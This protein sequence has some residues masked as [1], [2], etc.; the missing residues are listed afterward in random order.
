M[1]A[2][3]E[4]FLIGATVSI[5]PCLAFCSPVIL[6]YIAA[7]R[8]GWREGL[9]AMLAFSLARLAAYTALGLMAGL[10]GRWLIEAIAAFNRP[11]FA[12]SGLFI[13]ALGAFI[14][15]G[16]APQGHLCRM[17]QALDGELK[18]PALLGL[19]IGFTPC[20]PAAAVLAYIALKAGG[21][22][23]G[24][25]YGLSFGLGKALSLLLPLGVLSSALPGMLIKSQR[26]YACFRG[27][28]GALLLLI[29]LR[30]MAS[31]LFEGV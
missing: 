9:K 19:A 4:L 18:G 1:N 30:L 2:Y 10:L 20:L 3:I 13:S 11:I 6:P 14:V 23:R 8:R 24:A 15:A 16:Q 22:L 5:G 29:G 7:T 28:C 26:V 31:G 21:P 17:R 27:L 12:L 25:L